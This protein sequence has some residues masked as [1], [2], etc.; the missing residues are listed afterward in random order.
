[1]SNEEATAGIRAAIGLV[2]ARMMATAGSMPSAE[3]I[4]LVRAEIADSDPVEVVASLAALGEVLTT[5]ASIGVKRSRE[6][7]RQSTAKTLGDMK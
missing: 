6:E 1:M 4:S 7:I 2:N 3:F 5:I